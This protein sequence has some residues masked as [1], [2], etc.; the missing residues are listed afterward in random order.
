[1][2]QLSWMTSLTGSSELNLKSTLLKQQFKG[3]TG[4]INDLKS[5]V[6]Q[7]EDAAA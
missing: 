2:S 4:E 7:L 1:M 6:F 3:H 5:R